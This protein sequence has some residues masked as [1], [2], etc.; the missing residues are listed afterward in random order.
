MDDGEVT[1]YAERCEEEDAGVEVENHQSCAGLAQESSKGPVI[2]RGGECSPHGQ[3]DDEGEVR[4]GEVEHKN[5]SHR[6]ELHVAVD[7]SHHHTVP[8][9]TD[10]KVTA[11]DDGHQ[12]EDEFMA[13]S[14]AACQNYP[15]FRLCRNI[16]HFPF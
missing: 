6:L 15:V 11:V 7:D 8:D 2:A 3:S 14:I 9:D 16:R 10:D 5:V 4:N 1:V 12:G 13:S